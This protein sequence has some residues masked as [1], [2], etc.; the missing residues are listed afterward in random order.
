[1]RTHT[2]DTNKTRI[3][4]TRVAVAGIA[5]A[6]LSAAT[7]IGAGQA[8]A[9]GFPGGP[10]CNGPVQVMAASA[11]S[12]VVICPVQGP[13]GWAYSGEAKTTGDTVDIWGATQNSLGFHAVNNGYT[14]HVHR[15]RLLITAPDGSV[16]SSE[17]W[18]SYYQR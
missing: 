13:T 18:T 9:D 4:A 17:P 16:V 3:L 8:S 1:M 6:G 10:Y 14:Y 11:V 12:E 7:L 2:N 15:D 5:A